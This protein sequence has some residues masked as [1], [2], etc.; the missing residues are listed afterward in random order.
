MGAVVLA[1]MS[2]VLLA[3][4]VPGPLSSGGMSFLVPLAL[5]PL[6]VAIEILPTQA[7]SNLKAYMRVERMTPG[8]RSAMAFGL[9]WLA[10]STFWGMSFSWTVVPFLRVLKVSYPSA[11]LLHVACSLILGLFFVVL[12]APFIF[13]ASR[14]V[15]KFA[16]P[17]PLWAMIIITMAVEVWF[18]RLWPWTLGG[19]VQGSPSLN[20]WVSVFGASAL[21]PLVLATS[22]FLARAVT[23]MGAGYVRF[24]VTSG[25]LAFVWLFVWALGAWRLDV[26]SSRVSELKLSEVVAIQ[27]SFVSTS[28]FRFELPAKDANLEKLMA[29]SRAAVSE[30]SAMGGKPALVVWPEGV[31]PEGFSNT[32]E[33]LAAV[34][35]FVA[36]LGV[37]VLLSAFEVDSTLV[38]SRG[39][40]KAPAFNSA[41]LMRPDG[42]KSES[43]FQS[44]GAPFLEAVPFSESLPFLL[45]TFQKSFP[46]RQVLEKPTY[47]S[48][49]YSPDFKVSTL[50]SFDAVSWRFVQKVASRAEVGFFAHLSNGAYVHGTEALGLMHGMVRLRA[51]ESGRS[52]LS[53]SNAEIPVAFDPLGRHASPVAT[54]SQGWQV[55]SLPV[56]DAESHRSTFYTNF[57]NFPLAMATFAAGVAIL[58][59]LFRRTR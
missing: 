14:A 20:Q 46:E 51:L 9:V 28:N 3:L 13:N 41:F 57:G 10:G 5:F 6:L 17:F 40:E 16:D 19:F 59:T 42:S 8:R 52:I 27:P 44:V 32:P 31:L 33:S 15:R 54:N 24:F 18:P 30:W 45:E 58:L 39:L 25:V 56:F 35:D 29:L 55:F 50:I 48:V 4:G 1:V 36:K 53:V 11:Y 22:A 21:T 26:L 34:R 23:G 12:L 49:Y 38:A 47:L 7:P 37:P 43:Y 2:G